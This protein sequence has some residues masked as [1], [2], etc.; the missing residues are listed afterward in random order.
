MR[1]TLRFLSPEERFKYALE[2]AKFQCTAKNLEPNGEN[3]RNELG[4]I[5]NKIEFDKMD[6][7]FVETTVAE[8]FVLTKI[9]LF[10]LIN[11]KNLVNE[12]S[13][14]DILTAEFDCQDPEKLDAKFLVQNKPIYAFKWLLRIQCPILL[15]FFTVSSCY[16]DISNGVIIGGNVKFDQFKAFL[17]YLYTNK[18]E[19]NEE[20]IYVLTDLANQYNVL[21]L[22]NRCE[23]YL[24]QNAFYQN[25]E[26]HFKLAAL[27]E[28][29]KAIKILCK[30]IKIKDFWE[31]NDLL[32]I[33]KPLMKA[34]IQ[35]QMLSKSPEEEY[36]KALEWAKIRCTENNLEQ[37]VK[38][39]RNELGDI[40]D[41]IHF[42]QMSPE[43]VSTT[44]AESQ[45]L[46]DEERLKVLDK[47]AINLKLRSSFK[48]RLS[49]ESCG[50]REVHVLTEGA[51]KLLLQF[52]IEI[53]R[54]QRLE[55]GYWYTIKEETSNK[56]L[57]SICNERYVPKS[58]SPD[59]IEDGSIVLLAE[60]RNEKCTSI[61]FETIRKPLS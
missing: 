33:S 35:M 18:I 53:A 41:V 48:M 50:T 47:I 32:Q 26:N 15:K 20:N 11:A 39:C 17:R 52:F 43:F 31:T 12:K 37:S 38:N 29:A 9:E 22:Y 19:L 45:F 56:F 4:D 10:K 54:R 49:C 51:D 42:D 27:Y 5:F 24:C 2:W 61:Y 6:I 3:C 7:K 16:L 14:I 55:F 23:D 60:F 46:T 25:T 36:F 30:Y 59:L 40:V 57:R 1:A 58:I 13:L 21:S 34:C 44:I 8:S 28:M